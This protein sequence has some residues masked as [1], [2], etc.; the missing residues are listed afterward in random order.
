MK[1]TGIRFAVMM[2]MMIAFLGVLFLPQGAIAVIGP[3][4]W[5]EH[6]DKAKA[7]YLEFTGK[8][9]P[10][11]EFKAFGKTFTKRSSGI[12]KALTKLDSTFKSAADRTTKKKVAAYEKALKTF[13]KKRAAYKKVL[14]KGSDDKKARQYLNKALSAIKASAEAQAVILVKKLEGG[15]TE[16][17]MNA[18]K[19]KNMRASL[20]RAEEFI[21]KL[22]AKPDVK[23]FNEGI[24]KAGRDVWMQLLYF[25]KQKE[26]MKADP[27][28]LYEA[29]KPWGLTR[30]KLDGDAD[31]KAVKDAVK[32]FGSKIK[33]IKKWFKNE[34]L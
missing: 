22:K 10:K 34:K 7:D 24:D 12:D 23:L 11:S 5:K 1:K 17:V 9:K 3:G 33:A 8:K 6:W 15:G 29:L 20:K 13:L 32:V 19:P 16:E 25:V 14:K 26:K 4:Y 30:K 28:P 2:C 27:T 31:T 21:A 18:T